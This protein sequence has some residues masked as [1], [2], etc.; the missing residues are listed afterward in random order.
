M[1]ISIFEG[2]KSILKNIEEKYK[3]T[4]CWLGLKKADYTV[5]PV[6]ASEEKTYQE[7]LKQIK[8]R[9]DDSPFGNAPVGMSIKTRSI[10][11][12]NN[13]QEDERFLPVLGLL[14]KENFNSI[15][16]I[17]IFDEQ[18]TVFGVF[19]A[20]SDKKGFFNSDIISQI[21][22]DIDEI[23]PQILKLFSSNITI[24]EKLNEY[25]RVVYDIATY[26]N[27]GTASNMDPKYLALDVLNELDRL[28]DADGSELIIYNRTDN[29]IEFIVVSDL[30]LENFEIPSFDIY[31]YGGLSP[32]VR[33]YINIEHA[34]NIDYELDPY[35][36]EFYIKKGLK[37]INSTSINA[38]IY[39]KETFSILLL[40]RKD[41]K[42]ISEVELNI[43]KLINQVLFSA[44]V[45]RK[46]LSD[47]GSLRTHLEEIT[48]KDPITGFYN[49]EMFE[50][51]LEQELNK[52]ISRG[53]PNSFSYILIDV[54]NFKYINDAYG[55]QFGDLVLKDIAN[56]IEE[57]VRSVDI[58]ARLGGDEFGI[59]MSEMKIQ[60]SKV[61]M[62][63]INEKLNKDPIVV[64]DKK[65]RVS[66]SMGI[67]TY[68]EEDRK[69]L[70][71]ISSIKKHIK[72]LAENALVK[73][74]KQGKSSVVL[75]KG[76]NDKV[77]S[78]SVYGIINEAL[79]NDFIEPAYQ[80][81]VEI[82][83]GKIFGFEAL[84]RIKYNENIIYPDQF[85]E[86]AESLG[87]I[88]KIDLYMIEKS[89][90]RIA[91]L[92]DYKLFVNISAKAFSDGLFFKNVVDI[93]KNYNMQNRLYI[94]ITERETLSSFEK[95]DEIAEHLK[96]YGVEF[97]IDDFGSG[98]SSLLYLKFIKTN[99]L[100]I[101]GAFVKNIINDKND[102]AIV[103]GINFIS[104]QLDVKTLAEFIEDEDILEKLKAM[105]VDY[106]QGY[107]LG[108]PSFDLEKFIN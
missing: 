99:L 26:I 24:D 21:Q 34:T 6:V 45:V 35:A 72:M 100:K 56:V 70:E 32:F 104:K 25:L 43:I 3:L 106:G 73:A 80:P 23:K 85:V 57:N 4:F 27:K 54:D 37:F 93:V 10:Q 1:A 59:L 108:R 50:I 13:M 77:F 79:D 69:T 48:T 15:L 47:I 49:K 44:F 68:F 8:L 88:N 95:F 9:W 89:C 103:N 46:Y 22:K 76:K 53:L 94:E 30:F 29:K 105:G 7:Y 61:I 19:V 98:Y 16:S 63:R 67:S 84:C 97:V 102:E 40:T 82:L 12:A 58:I 96:Y 5:L 42:Y 64:N 2:V 83:S 38:N 41:K 107:Y 90:K 60:S 92:K 14:K 71:N 78:E 36:Y 87:L 62:E 86:E 20:Y 55:Y 39:N 33:H 31:K 66:L 91:P 75:A 81:I 51:F 101:D 11:Y 28:L 65:I 17:P 18:Y 52:A 74:K